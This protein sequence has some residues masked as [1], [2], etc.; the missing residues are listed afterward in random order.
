MLT[1]RYVYISDNNHGKT[2][3]ESLCQQPSER[4]LDIKGPVVIGDNVWIGD[5]VSILSGVTIGEGS[6]IGCN[7]V[8][9]HDIPPYSVVGG[10]PAKIIKSVK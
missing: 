9:T 8:V 5:K 2:D 6:I 4:E 10:V 7:A 3:Y 1:G